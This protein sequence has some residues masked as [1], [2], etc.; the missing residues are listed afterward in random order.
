MLVGLLGMLVGNLA[1]PLRRHGVLL[2]LFV[3]S[4]FVVLNSLTV[5]VRRCFVMSGSRVMVFACR[6]FHWHSTVLS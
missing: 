2:G 3:L 5:M 4:L 6:V 1:V